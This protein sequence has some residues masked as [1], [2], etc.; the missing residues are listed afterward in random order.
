VS[1]VVQLE[2]VN[3]NE[4]TLTSLIW[5]VPVLS[6]NLIDTAETRFSERS[7]SPGMLAGHWSFA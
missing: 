2:D 3:V 5:A 7:E 4:V 1:L 6:Y